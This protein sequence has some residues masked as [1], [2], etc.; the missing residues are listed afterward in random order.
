MLMAPVELCATHTTRPK[1][2]LLTLLKVV[3]YA[4]KKNKYNVC[5]RAAISTTV[6]EHTGVPWKFKGRSFISRAVRGCE[7]PNNCAQLCCQL[8]F[9]K[10]CSFI[11]LAPCWYA[12]RQSWLKTE[13]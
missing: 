3:G 6:M 1:N 10:L 12:V 9:L 8:F 13:F 5:L 7:F 11:I 4:K 2:F